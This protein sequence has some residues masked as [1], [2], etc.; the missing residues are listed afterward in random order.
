MSQKK[1]E[2]V[3]KGVNHDEKRDKLRQIAESLRKDKRGA[4]IL[5]KRMKSNQHDEDNVNEIEEVLVVN[6]DL[7]TAVQSAAQVIQYGDTAG[8][9]N[10]VKTLR[11]L[12]SSSDPHAAI[13]LVIDAGLVPLLCSFLSVPI[14]DI[15]AEAAWCLTNIAGGTHDQTGHVLVAVPIFIQILGGSEPV[16]QEQVCWAVGN[17]AGDADDYRQ[18]LVANGALRAVASLLFSS[19]QSVLKSLHKGTP[20]SFSSS[21][22]V[23]ESR[24]LTAA[25]ALSNLARGSTTA[26]AFIESEITAGLLGI[27]EALHQFGISSS[28]GGIMSSGHE[29]ESA[30]TAAGNAV[31]LSSVSGAGALVEF[32]HNLTHEI[33]WVL[34]FLAAKEEAAVGHMIAAQG[35]IPAIC[36][37]VSRTDAMD[38]RAIPL[39]RCLGNLTS[40]PLEWID[41]LLVVSL[42]GVSVSVSVSG[43]GVTDPST[44]VSIPSFL[45]AVLSSWHSQ[46]GGEGGTFAAHRAVVKETLWVVSNLLAGTEQHREHVLTLGALPGATCL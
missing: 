16:L 18:V 27:L 22:A 29:K 3:L 41:P 6:A 12:I 8:Q 2:T 38:E 37:V 31:T 1:R 10:G 20:A 32:V 42:S 43:G 21:V 35:L 17:I 44:A 34:C 19:T 46:G 45:I 39:V 24:P 33:M 11:R 5:A 26:S 13:Q 23:I 15:Q 4:A 7:I 30:V 14:K 25:W 9:A 36:S 40:G 28:I